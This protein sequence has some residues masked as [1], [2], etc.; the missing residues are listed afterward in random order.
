MGVQVLKEAQVPEE[1]SHE[2]HS[3]SCAT[4]TVF[5]AEITLIPKSAHYMI[6]PCFREGTVLILFLSTL[7]PL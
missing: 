5:R 3:C 1:S 7:S 6:K 2:P 4:S